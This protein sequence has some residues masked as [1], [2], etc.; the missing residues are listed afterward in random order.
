MTTELW[1]FLA[2][3]KPDIEARGPT[4]LPPNVFDVIIDRIEAAMA[5]ESGAELK[6][7]TAQLT[8]LAEL[9]WQHSSPTVQRAMQ[10]PDTNPDVYAAGVLAQ[11]GFAQSFAARVLHQRADDRY[12]QRLTDP[13]YQAYVRAL[14]TSTLRNKD[15]IN[16]VNETKETVSRKLSVLQAL[17]IVE[18]RRQGTH[19]VNCLAPNARDILEQRNIAPLVATS[20]QIARDVTHEIERQAME[21][22][23]VYM[24]APILGAA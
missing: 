23:P 20:K 21:L 3:L 10:E 1:P 12:A 24:R 2:E 9:L 18:R 22:P 16:V 17:G 13:R 5:A 7:T 15:F 11:A 6:A 8:S 14:L 19:V 4:A